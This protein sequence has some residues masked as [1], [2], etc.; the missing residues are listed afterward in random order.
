MLKISL[1]LLMAGKSERFRKGAI[2]EENKILY[3]V[4][5][6]PLFTYSMDAFCSFK[7][8]EK[9]L[10]VV[11]PENE[12]AIKNV[13]LQNY[14]HF[15]IQYVYGGETRAQSVRNALKEVDSEYVLIH[16]AARPLI[17]KED[18]KKMIE[19]M[20]KYVCGSLYHKVYDTIKYV[21]AK[22]IETIER[23]ALKAVST[24]QFF[25]KSLYKD[26]LNPKLEDNW[27]TDELRIFEENKVDKKQICF[28]EASNSN[29][30]VTTQKDIEEIAFHLDYNQLYKIGHSF[31]FHPFEVG[32]KCILGG[33]EIPYEKGL[34]GHSDADV[35]YHVVAESIMG[36]LGIGDLGTLF[37]DYDE[38]YKD[39]SSDY[40]VKTVV[41]KLDESGYMVQN[42][43]VIIYLEKPNLKEYKVQMATNIKQLTTCQYVNVKATTL[44]KKGVIGNGYGIASEAVTLIKRKGYIENL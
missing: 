37:P 8:I 4:H 18:I 17:A 26:I 11:S 5:H 36:A 29:K 38:K 44:E 25:A 7:E 42:I 13:V 43:D 14:A 20:P 12:T 33:V 3:T 32:R 31:D 40:F 1:I 23:D 15:N 35:V 22:A 28:I 39:M 16:D 19:E 34:M 2:D 41:K 24:P 10:M 30:K 6:R 27:I 9:I 21:D